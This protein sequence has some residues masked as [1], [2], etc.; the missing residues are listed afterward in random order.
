V[1]EALTRFLFFR[2]P[3]DESIGRRLKAQSAL[4]FSYAEVGATRGGPVPEG[5][6]VN[7]IRGRVGT[8]RAAFAAASGALSSWEM[9]N[10]GWTWLCPPGAPARKGELFAVLA[11]HF[12]L[13]SL[14]AC[15]V[16]YTL[17]E[18]DEAGARSGFAIG[19]LPGHV[20]RGE[21]R[22]VIEWDRRTDEVTYELFAFAQSK[23]WLGGL[24]YPPAR[25]VQ[26]RFAADSLDAMRRAVRRRA[27]G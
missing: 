11:R 21:E 19:T 23:P 9:Y 12:G 26:R 3:P 5:Y 8:G 17:R 27:R 22:F 4:A 16:V 7:R 2:R 15:R 6:P 18:E 24:T 20:E 14:N 25:F 13:W 10:T 1:L